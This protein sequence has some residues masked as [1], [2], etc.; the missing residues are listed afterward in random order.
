METEPGQEFRE[1][2]VYLTPDEAEELRVALAY[3]AEEQPPDPDWHMHITDSN[4]RE[5]TVAVGDISDERFASRFAG[6]S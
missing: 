3:R 5:L 2:W 4:G 6:P 1:V